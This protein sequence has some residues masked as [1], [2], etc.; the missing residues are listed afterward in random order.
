M[1]GFVHYGY[2]G[3]GSLRADGVGWVGMGGVEGLEED[4]DHGDEQ[5]DSTGGYEYPQ[6]QSDSV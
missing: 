2:L 5:R 4:R 1:R 6:V 3:R